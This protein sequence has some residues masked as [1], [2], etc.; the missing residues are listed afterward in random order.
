[1]NTCK[2]V[3]IVSLRLKNMMAYNSICRMLRRESDYKF[4]FG[5]SVSPAMHAWPWDTW[6]AGHWRKF[7]IGVD[8]TQAG[9]GAIFI[10]KPNV[11]CCIE[12]GLLPQ[13]RG[14]GYGGIA[15][16]L[17]ISKCFT[18]YGARLVE[19]FALSTNLR[20]IGMVDWMTLEGRLQARHLID[21]Q[22]VDELIYKITKPEWAARQENT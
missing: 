11:V 15:G 13:Y 10:D 14:M 21:G 8:G 7:I 19:S 17:L 16:R 18:E 20:S 1:M 2:G 3:G 6:G 9:F 12:L 22:E 4:A 5:N